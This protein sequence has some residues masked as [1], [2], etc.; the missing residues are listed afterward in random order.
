MFITNPVSLSEGPSPSLAQHEL[1]F[2][3]SLCS[4]EFI[5]KHS[6]RARGSSS[7]MHGSF[8]TIRHQKLMPLNRGILA[9]ECTGARC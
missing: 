3:T 4:S 1:A 9:V 2:Q 5:C 7:Y 8:A 6:R